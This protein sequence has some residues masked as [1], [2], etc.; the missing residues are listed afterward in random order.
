MIPLRKIVIRDGVRALL[1]EIALR[2]GIHIEPFVKDPSANVVATREFRLNDRGIA[3][4]FTLELCVA[5]V[6]VLIPEQVVQIAQVRERVVGRG[7]TR[8]PPIGHQRIRAILPIDPQAA[9][10]VVGRR[11]KAVLFDVV[12]HGYDHAADITRRHTA[13]RRGRTRGRGRLWGILPAGQTTARSQP[14]KQDEQAHQCR[15]APSRGLPH[16][17]LRSAGRGPSTSV[18]GA[19]QYTIRGRSTTVSRNAI[20]GPCRLSKPALRC[21]DS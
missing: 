2:E 7:M 3:L 15:D 19:T 14:G 13:N 21:A 12:Q 10:A 6:F 17:L 20:L 16:A 8:F 4:D 18:A 1:V 9:E 5:R 11:I